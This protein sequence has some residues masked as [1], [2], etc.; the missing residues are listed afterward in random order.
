MACNVIYVAV[1][2]ESHNLNRNTPMGVL[3]GTLAG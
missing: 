3:I 1:P 2:P